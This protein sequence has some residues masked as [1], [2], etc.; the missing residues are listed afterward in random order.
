MQAHTA[1]GARSKPANETSSAGEQAILEAAVQLF[2]QY[3]YDGVSMRGI[4]EAAGVSKA[5]IYHHF[6]SKE[7][8]YLAIVK[9]SSTRLTALL[10]DLA[11]GSADFPKRVQEFAGRHLEHLFDNGTTVRLVLREAFA[12]DERRSRV[13]VEQVVGALFRQLTEIFEAG[14]SAGVV[15]DDLDPGLCATLLIG[16]D[17]FYFQAQGLLRQIPQ[18]GFARQPARYAQQ[19]SDIL[20]RGMLTPA[21]AGRVSR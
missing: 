19:M 2:S 3:G 20:L 21:D 9:H 17:L 11:A 6:R 7:A 14:Q 12:G 13:L 5:N 15:R 8:L 1:A 18:A 10:E 4:A 16:A